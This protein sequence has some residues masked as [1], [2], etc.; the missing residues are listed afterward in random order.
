MGSTE[1]P[2]LLKETLQFILDKAK[3]QDVLYFFRDLSTNP[4]SRRPLAQFFM[5]QY[6]VVGI[7]FW[8][9]VNLRED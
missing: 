2:E 3:D 7:L 1:D 4:K 9:S 6:D 5:N 8:I